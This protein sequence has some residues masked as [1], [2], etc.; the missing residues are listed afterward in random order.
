[1]KAEEIAQWSL[2]L[3]NEIDAI[4]WGSYQQGLP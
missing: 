1:M 4:D 3:L 2:Q